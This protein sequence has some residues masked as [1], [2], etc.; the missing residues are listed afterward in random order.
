MI[1]SLI[2]NI[3]FAKDRAELVAVTHA[4]D[5]VLLWNYYVVPQW[6][7]P[8]E[9]VAWWDMFGRPEK[10]PS[11]VPSFLHSWWI[12]R[13]AR[14]SSRRAGSDGHGADGVRSTWLRNWAGVVA[15]QV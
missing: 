14:R 10:L 3:V 6:Y 1:D 11:Q 7:Y 15:A 9:W 8:D 4:L 12:D 5:R 13:Q 2:D